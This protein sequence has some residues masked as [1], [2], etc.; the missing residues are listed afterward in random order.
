MRDYL[1]DGPNHHIWS[2]QLHPMTAAGHD[3]NPSL[4]ATRQ[5]LVL[6]A[7]LWARVFRRKHDQ[8]YVAQSAAKSDFFRDGRRA[9]WHGLQILGHPLEGLRVRPMRPD[10]RPYF[11]R[12]FANLA[13]DILNKGGPTP[14]AGAGYQ[15]WQ[16]PPSSS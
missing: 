2:I 9:F 6:G 7:L 12:E 10:H 16:P 13:Q 15:L 1:V 11:G 5:T 4:E 3:L 8:W 14:A